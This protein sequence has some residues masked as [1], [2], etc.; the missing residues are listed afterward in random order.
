MDGVVVDDAVEHFVALGL[1][2]VD[3]GEVVARHTAQQ[4]YA[5]CFLRVKVLWVQ[6][7]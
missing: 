5:F 1:V 2:E 4:D 3:V 6:G 7:C